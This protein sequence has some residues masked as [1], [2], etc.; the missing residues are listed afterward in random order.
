MDVVEKD[1]YNDD[2]K[3]YQKILYGGISSGAFV[4][5]THAIKLLFTLIFPPLGE[6]IDTVAEYVVS[7][8]PYVTWK[9]FKALFE[10]DT[11]KRILYSF[12]LTSLFYIP[13]LIYTLSKFETSTPN[14]NGTVHCDGETGECVLV[15][16]N[17]PP[18]TN[19]K[20]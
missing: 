16:N 13:G 4:I 17:P 1:I 20:T 11:L 18:T 2:Y 15:T 14:I 9:M 10:Y 12:V 3:L 7:E 5:P 6:I 8:F 19:T